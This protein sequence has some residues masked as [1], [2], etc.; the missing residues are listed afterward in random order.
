LRSG[1]VGVIWTVAVITAVSEAGINIGAFVATATVVGGAIGFGAQTLIRD[2]IGGFFVL[3]EDQYGTG[4]IVD[5][6]HAL[7]T[8]EKVT[9]R[10][11]RVRD[12]EGRVWFVPHGNVVRVA[13]LSRSSQ[14]VLNVEVDRASD[15]AEVLAAL[16]ALCAELAA[17]QNVGTLVVGEPSAAGPT[18]M[19]DDRVI[20]QLVAGTRPGEQDGVR[21]RWRVAV[22]AAFAD[23]RLTAPPRPTTT[24]VLAP[25]QPG[26]PP[27]VMP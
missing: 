14:A 21:R 7:G 17:D 25:G 6:G 27:S 11:V 23:G 4:D 22:L 18:E 26:L 2:V 20:Y 8:V 3:A 19:R 5:L 1:L 9:L 16:D 12:G 24:V 10:S 13:N 15:H